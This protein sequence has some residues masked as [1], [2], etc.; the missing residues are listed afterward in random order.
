MSTK[1][2][3]RDRGEERDKVDPQADVNVSFGRMLG[4]PWAAQESSHD[5]RRT[6]LT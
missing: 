6:A 5:W 2:D 3:R 4:D 1:R